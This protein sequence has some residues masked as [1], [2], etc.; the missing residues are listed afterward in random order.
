MAG[1]EDNLPKFNHA[2][3]EDLSKIKRLCLHHDHL[4]G[5]CKDYEFMR[6]QRTYDHM[7]DPDFCC[8]TKKMDSLDKSHFTSLI[9][10]LDQENCHHLF[11]KLK[12]VYDQ[13]NNL[14]KKYDSKVEGTPYF[15]SAHI[16]LKSILDFK[17]QNKNDLKNY[18]PF[19]CE[20]VC[21]SLKLL[22]ADI[23]LYGMGLFCNLD[24]GK[25]LSLRCSLFSFKPH[26]TNNQGRGWHRSIQCT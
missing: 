24:Q 3:P 11:S 18:M 12:T 22:S 6:Q 21:R 23:V 4:K 9:I 5:L 1:N 2:Q 7:N 16:T 20:P 10:K 8:N 25:G 19:I 15:D 26:D 17:K 13:V 14:L